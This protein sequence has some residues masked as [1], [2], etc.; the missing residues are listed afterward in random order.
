V[1]GRSRSR[2]IESIIDEMKRLLSNNFKEIV[3]TGIC[4]GAWG[5]DFLPKKSLYELLKWLI[6]LGEDFRIRLS[7]IEPKY[8]NNRLLALIKSSSKLCKHL[9]IPLQSGDNKIL[10]MMNR[11]YTADEYIKIAE[12]A[13]TAIPEISITTDILI[14]FPGEAEANFY[15]TYR[16]IEKINPSRIHIFSYSKRNG[17]A[18]AD[19]RSE[20]PRDIITR[21]IRKLKALAQKTS[22]KYRKRF[23][24]KETKVLV[25]HTKDKDT[26][27]LK[28]YDDKYIK[29]LLQGPDDYISKICSVRIK[30]VEPGYTIGQIV[31]N[32]LK[33][34]K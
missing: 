12:M 25:E 4:L 29:I 13:K 33:N 26:G 31:Q 19:L 2:D 14:G 28:G 23:L 27:L 30:K 9:H 17:T 16:L 10:K 1:R 22:Y 24:N 11:P 6:E 18:A 15:N 32:G 3:L 5:E 8:V 7:S 34:F 21:R 20:I